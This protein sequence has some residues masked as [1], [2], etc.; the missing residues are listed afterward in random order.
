MVGAVKEHAVA[1]DVG[2]V[3]EQAHD[4]I[5]RHRLAA[6]RLTHN[7]QNLPLF[8]VKGDVAHGVDDA[9]GRSQNRPRD[10]QLSTSCPYRT[11]VLS[12]VKSFVEPIADEIQTQHG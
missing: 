12:R 9:P 11:S 5:H 3:P 1:V 6:S 2:G 7:A 10:F 4:G 8:D